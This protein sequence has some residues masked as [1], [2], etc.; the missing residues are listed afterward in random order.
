MWGSYIVTLPRIHPTTFAE[1]TIHE[2]LG[3]VDLEE[4]EIKNLL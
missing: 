4:E 3:T 2:R 1:I